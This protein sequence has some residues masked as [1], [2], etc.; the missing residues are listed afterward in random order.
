[1]TIF[2]R[3]QTK[4]EINACVF[5]VDNE[6]CSITFM[7]KSYNASIVKM[8]P[9]MGNSTVGQKT[10]TGTWEVETRKRFY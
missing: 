4:C 1:M 3:V 10:A 7:I 2:K 9:K 8:H 5:P 6:R